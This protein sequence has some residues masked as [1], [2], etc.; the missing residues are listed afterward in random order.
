MKRP[1]STL[2]ICCCLL[3]LALTASPAIA[4]GIPAVSDAELARA[5]EL[6]GANAPE[7]QSALDASADDGTRRAAMRFTV[8]SLP[9][10]D[11][12]SISAAEL[13]ANLDM[14]LSVRTDFPWGSDCDLATWAHFVLPPRVSQE[15]LSDWRRFFLAEL[16]NELSGATTLDEA[17][18][19]VNKWCGQRVGFKQTQ[20]R[21][22]GPL[23][24]LASGYGR[25]EEMVIFYVDAC[26]SVGIPA[27]MAYCPYWAVSDN[28]H[29]WVE[30]LG[31]D[32]NWHYTGGCEPRDQLDD[33]WF[34]GAVKNAPLI[35]SMAFGVPDTL[36]DSVLEVDRTVG[37]RYTRFNSTS[38]YRDTGLLSVEVPTAAGSTNAHVSVHVFNFGALRQIAHVQ[39]DSQ[40]RARIRLGLGSFV[41]TTDAPVETRQTLVE[42][43]AGEI[44]ELYWDSLPELDSQIL[45]QF[46]PDAA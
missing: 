34:N 31:S 35:C 20:R 18:V 23:A 19:L 30:V 39:L 15:P 43:S 40:G 42:I 38:F 36:D 8:A 7:L 45:L 28:N 25:C 17:A 41:I 9:T 46:P 22:Q 21:D 10:C 14:A 32:G 6:A 27:R 26:R 5:L 13:T 24:T 11:L 1:V 3:G 44:T 2:L 16:G 37:A 4:A 33:A 29:A 12:G